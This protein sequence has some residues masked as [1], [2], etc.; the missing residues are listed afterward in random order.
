MKNSNNISEIIDL[1]R[2]LKRYRIIGQI[3]WGFVNFIHDILKNDTTEEIIIIALLTSY[4]FNQHQN[5]CLDLN[6]IANE[7]QFINFFD[8]I[9]RLIPE[10]QQKVVGI[11]KKIF[12]EPQK[13]HEQLINPQN[14]SIVHVKNNSAENIT[15]SPLIF[16][17]KNKIYLQRYYSYEQ[18]LAHDIASRVRNNYHNS[19]VPLLKNSESL[20]INNL[21]QNIYRI[22]KRFTPS[23]EI[24]YQ[25]LGIIN[26]YI[27]NF[28]IITGGPGT[29]KTTVITMILAL[30]LENKSDLKINIV[31]PSGKAQARVSESIRD[32][33]QFLDCS[34][35]IIEKLQNIETSTIHR[36]LG[37]VYNSPYFKHNRKN[38]LQADVIIIDEL[39]MVSSMLMAKLMTAINNGTK[40]VLLGDRDQLSSVE[41]GALMANLCD[42]FSI[43]KF[44]NE[45]FEFLA[46]DI[47]QLADNKELFLTEYKNNRNNTLL[48]NNIAIKLQH[49]YRFSPDKGI[50]IV[51]KKINEVGHSFKEQEFSEILHAMH[52]DDT[53]RFH[54]IDVNDLAKNNDGAVEKYLRKFVKELKF[55]D[56]KTE[57]EIKFSNYLQC[58]DVKE[59]Y[60]LLER[61]KILVAEN[62]SR[63]GVHNINKLIEEILGL[64]VGKSLYHG[65][66]IIVTEND[67]NLNLFNGDIGLF[68]RDPET[69]R[70]GVYFPDSNCVD[71]F[72]V[73]N[74]GRLPQH[75]TVFAMSVHRSQGSGFEKILF[76]LLNKPNLKMINRE[77]VY[78]A[79]TRAK[80]EVHLLYNHTTLKNS[81]YRQTD[82]STGLGE[83]LQKMLESIS[84]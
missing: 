43:N 16:D 9:E 46:S 27:N 55:D 69:N 62:N 22:G 31:A 47:G 12:I 65:R 33:L 18:A 81:L 40:I 17:G 10:E 83:H 77:L 82:R 41:A 71:D 7:E 74:P 13:L 53:Q 1:V 21:L 76:L 2:E 56:A 44:S 6:L 19:I 29:G 37:T 5:I 60:R 4:T 48:S 49:S 67:Y 8:N 28:S 79:I 72:I 61:F 15:L 32:E 35:E 20:N 23:T 64:P 78:T 68:W 66:V 73:I 52:Y 3:D 39:S 26:A 84:E 51:T 25:L 38:K 63:Y 54:A 75:E 50:G 30:L 70:I 34:D 36:L 42:V 24:N 58:S 80:K 57:K 11:L 45:Y 59:A 14:N